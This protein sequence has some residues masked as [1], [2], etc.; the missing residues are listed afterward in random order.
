MNKKIILIG[1]MM[2]GCMSFPEI[3]DKTLNDRV[4]ACSAGFSEQV[5]GSLN[6]SMDKAH[7]I[8]G[9][10]SNI[11]EETRSIIFSQIPEK[12]RL[13]AYEDYIGCVEKNWNK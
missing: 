3:Q 11:K 7:L 10:N 1:L 2:T 9:V 13:K 6:V 5:Q 8:G 12:D 4:K